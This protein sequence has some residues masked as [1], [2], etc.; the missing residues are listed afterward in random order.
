[1]SDRVWNKTLLV[2]T[3]IWGFVVAGLLWKGAIYLIH[4]IPDEYAL[5]VVPVLVVLF[6]ASLK[7]GH[8]AGWWYKRYSR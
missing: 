4:I 1:M 7:T 2:T 3:L 8:V 5:L 6:F